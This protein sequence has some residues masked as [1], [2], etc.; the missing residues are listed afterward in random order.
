V[1]SGTTQLSILTCLVAVSLCQAAPL[2]IWV[3]GDETVIGNA[4][5]G[6]SARDL[7]RDLLRT[8][9][10]DFEYT[11][12]LTDEV[13]L[14][15]DGHSTYTITEMRYGKACNITKGCR[16][17]DWAPTEWDISIVVLG[18]W[19]CIQVQDAYVIIKDHGDSLERIVTFLRGAEMRTISGGRLEGGSAEY[20][21]G[22]A[23]GKNKKVILNTLPP[24][25]D[26]DVNSRI[27]EFNE[28]IK[29]VFGDL[30][31]TPEDGDTPNTV[32]DLHSVMDMYKD[33]ARDGKNALMWIP[34]AEGQRKMAFAWYEAITAYLKEKADNDRSEL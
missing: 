14:A 5:L 26:P 22:A 32:V 2:R 8:D 30:F 17:I 6:R 16:L 31:N 3:V 20:T 28:H 24:H 10:V 7:L 4:T 18:M 9:G 1:M 25:R 33:T 23:F 11:G 12:G 34:N 19:D 13:G 29:Y 27:E 21:P 15:H